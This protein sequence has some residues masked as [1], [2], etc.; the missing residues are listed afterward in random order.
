[1]G[2]LQMKNE[3]KKVIQKAMAFMIMK[4]EVDVSLLSQIQ[5]KGILDT[6]SVEEILVCCK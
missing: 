3:H 6:Q 5:E 2:L 4:L 1:M